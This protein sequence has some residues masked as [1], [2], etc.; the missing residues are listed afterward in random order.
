MQNCK[1]LVLALA[2]ALPAAAF[3]GPVSGD[4]VKI[5][6]LTDMSGVYASVGGKGSVIAAQMAIADFGGKV[7]DKPIELVSADHQNKADIGVGKAREWFDTQGVDMVNDLL[8]SGV[9]I[10]VQKL[11]TEKKRITINNGAGSTA[12]TGKECG[13]Y[14][15]HYAYDTYALAKG[16]ATALMKQGL[17]SWFFLQADYAFGAAL[18]GDASKIVAATG[19]KVL[20]TVKHPLSSTDFSSYLL[21]AQDSKA[22]VVGLANAGAD[23]VN[24]VKQA[25]EFGLKQTIAGLLVFDSDVKALGLNA[26]QGMKFTTAYSWELNPEMEAFGKKFFAKAGFMPTMDHAGVYSSTLHYLNAIKAAGTDDADAVMKKMRETKVNDFFAKN[27]VIREDGR[28]VHDM[29]LVEV[30]KP[31]ESK[32]AWDQLKLVATIPGDVAFKPLS[33]SECPLIKK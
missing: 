21:Q 27:G 30:L 8:N 25:K 2:L 22:K 12:L 6:I 32:G 5:G 1:P 26:A 3:A 14:G 17:D 7:L 24:A 4:M 15:I 11:G 13:P 16:T 29:Y 28:M 9:G 31:S 19:G 10:A 18:Q 20:G 23:F 33:V